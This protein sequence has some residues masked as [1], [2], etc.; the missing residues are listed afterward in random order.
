VFLVHLDA[1]PARRLLQLRA[2]DEQ[3][4]EPV[5]GAAECARVLVGKLVALALRL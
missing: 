5:T 4:D 1:E 3:R 2:V